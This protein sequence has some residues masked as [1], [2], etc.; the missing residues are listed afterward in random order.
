MTQTPRNTHTHTLTHT[1]THTPSFSIPQAIDDLQALLG[2]VV[3]A[4]GLSKVRR[5]PSAW[6]LKPLASLRSSL[7]KRN[8]FGASKSSDFS[9]GLN[10]MN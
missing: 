4:P 8:L 9:G 10:D 2:V 3:R 5:A 6:L 7:S 1:H